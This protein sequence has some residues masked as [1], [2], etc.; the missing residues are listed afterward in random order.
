MASG[1]DKSLCLS[2]CSLLLVGRPY[3][4][5]QLVGTGSA[6]EATGIALQLGLDIIHA[7]AVDQLGNCLQVAVAAAFKIHI[8]DLIPV[9]VEIDQN[10][11]Y[12]LRAILIMCH[13]SLFPV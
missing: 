6:A 4:L 11:T 1:Q 13:Y 9:Q 2:I 5:C 3:S 12:A 10:R 8:G 7:C